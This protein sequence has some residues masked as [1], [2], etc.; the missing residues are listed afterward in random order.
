M[1][2]INKGVYM[3]YLKDFFAALQWASKAQK[4]AEGYHGK[5][6]GWSQ[7]VLDQAGKA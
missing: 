2:L 1:R 5:R 6:S 3:K 4:A 7:Y